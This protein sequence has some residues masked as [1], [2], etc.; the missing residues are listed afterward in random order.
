MYLEHLRRKKINSLKQFIEEILEST[1]H[2]PK[3]SMNNEESFPKISI[4]LNILNDVYLGYCTKNGYKPR[5]IEEE[6]S[7]FEDYN[8]EVISRIDKTT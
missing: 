3:T 7:L 1:K 4:E 8:L 2:F 6:M 5:I